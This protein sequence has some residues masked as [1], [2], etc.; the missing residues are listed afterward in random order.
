MAEPSTTSTPNPL[1]E[2]GRNHPR[3]RHRMRPVEG[4]E[5][6]WYCPKHDLYAQVVD[7]ATAAGLDR[8]DG[9]PLPDGSAGTVLRLG[10]ER[11]GGTI[12][13]VRSEA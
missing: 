5:N 10:D 8:G 11:A 13:Y 4:R 9:H 2:I 12:V 1:C 7:S 3:D 6:V